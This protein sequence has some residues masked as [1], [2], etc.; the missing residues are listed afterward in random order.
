MVAVAPSPLVLAL[1]SAHITVLSVDACSSLNSHCLSEYASA[2]PPGSK[3][4][5]GLRAAAEAHTCLPDLPAQCSIC[6]PL[7]W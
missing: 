4:G 6:G 3:H 2:S 1:A 7:L 5:A